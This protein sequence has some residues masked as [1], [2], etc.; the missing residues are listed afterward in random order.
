MDL[1]VNYLEILALESGDLEKIKINN[2]QDTEGKHSENIWEEE[3]QGRKSLLEGYI[4]RVVPRPEQRPPLR[5]CLKSKFSDNPP[6]DFLN[7]K[8][9]GGAQQKF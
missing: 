3:K 5:S 4:S 2:Q 1:H 8:F 6:P 9:W 7:L